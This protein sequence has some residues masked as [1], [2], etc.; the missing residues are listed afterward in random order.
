MN[1]PQAILLIDDN[2]H[3]MVAR[4]R[5]LNDL[6]FEVQTAKSGEEA[7]AILETGKHFAVI[8]TDYRMGGMNGIELAE[9]ARRICPKSRTILLSALVEPWGMTVESTGTDAVIMKS[10]NEIAELTR[11]VQHLLVKR[12]PVSPVKKAAKRNVVK[13]G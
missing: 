4:R 1:L 11:T 8:V 3:G 9:H 7:L 6:G 12:K 2:A 10:S 5:V 13:N